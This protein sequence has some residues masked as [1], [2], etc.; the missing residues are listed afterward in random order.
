MRRLHK[1]GV[2]LLLS[3]ALV[4]VLGLRTELGRASPVA[5]ANPSIV[6]PPAV[7]VVAGSGFRSPTADST[8]ILTQA[9]FRDT[10][11]RQLGTGRVGIV[12]SGEQMQL[13]AGIGLKVF[14]DTGTLQVMITAQLSDQVPQRML[15]NEAGTQKQLSQFGLT[16]QTGQ[17][18]RQPDTKNIQYG[19]V[20]PTVSAPT[21]LTFQIGLTITPLFGIFVSPGEYSTELLRLLILPQPYTPEL[22]S[23]HVVLFDGRSTDVQVAG[24]LPEIA[25]D[26]SLSAGATLTAQ[27][28]G[29]AT[30]RLTGNGEVGSQTVAGTL[31]FPP[32]LLGGA[33]T[34]QVAPRTIYGVH[35][36]D[37]AGSHGGQVAFH[38]A[39]PSGLEATNVH[40]FWH[41]EEL[42][43]QHGETVTLRGL[44]LGD[45]GSEVYAIAD[46]QKGG[47]VLE[48]EVESNHAHLTVQPAGYTMAPRQ[49][50]LIGGPD[51]SAAQSQT[52][53]EFQ[54]A[55][56]GDLPKITWSV[57]GPGPASIDNEG[58]LTASKIP[59]ASGN[60]TVQA[61]VTVGDELITTLTQQVVVGRLTAAVT[62]AAGEDARFD[63][64]TSNGTAWRYTWQTKMPTD[65]NW[66]TLPDEKGA[67]LTLKNV[68]AVDAGR[69]VRV[70]I[71]VA[72]GFSGT[73]QVTSNVGVLYIEMPRTDYTLRTQS[74]FLFTA[75]DDEL[76]QPASTT[77]T[78][79]L[80]GVQE[81]QLGGLTWKA[82]APDA[83]S[84]S[85]AVVIT[86]S[87]TDSRQATVHTTGM[88][89]VAEI[90][91]RYRENGVLQ[92]SRVQLEVLSLADITVAAN[93]A[94]IF[95]VPTMTAPTS[96]VPTYDWVRMSG[97]QTVQVT[98][99]PTTAAVTQVASK[100]TSALN[101]THYQLTMQFDYQGQPVSLHS[102]VA[103]ISVT[104]PDGLAMQTLPSFAFAKYDSSRTNAQGT[105]YFAPTVAE[106][107]TGAFQ[108]KDPLP[109]TP[110]SDPTTADWLRDSNP[111][112]NTLLIS[113]TRGPES[114]E[115]QLG[116]KMTRFVSGFSGNSI[117]PQPETGALQLIFHTE[118]GTALTV[119]SVP[120]GSEDAT[121][122][123]K[124]SAL[125]AALQQAE[126]L[127][128]TVD[129]FL[130]LGPLP[131]TR[132][133]SYQ[134]ELTW[135]LALVPQP[136]D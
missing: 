21:W 42:P 9:N 88:P 40:W 41:G 26:F 33:A 95:Q 87:R 77:T 62:T 23:D 129:G 125:P 70:L 44:R 47:V 116:L 103:A 99:R 5:A 3:I 11:G 57:M 106:L 13:R 66:T 72:G 20:A 123:F 83:T 74:P 43:D 124:Q 15:G 2:L 85:G 84:S 10:A 31:Y 94:L 58:T 102:N 7:P 67:S 53:F 6:L 56:T 101:G 14:E 100:V 109:Q 76:G 1:K 78:V 110:G 107:I 32:L 134:A 30:L 113:D 50:L 120:I 25:P 133:N 34:I 51:T 105:S 93:N 97:G 29:S 27:A 127:T 126:V 130:K 82:I 111:T 91:A 79:T 117:A 65:A 108:G 135:E 136:E 48:R 16:Y 17:S 118:D 92:E 35:L 36:P 132:V 114:G 90:V 80:A 131:S 89:G 37:Q 39:L 69:Q 28:R 22:T 96:V 61:R 119:P 38:L 49:A 60:V 73:T 59:G 75:G 24:L 71:Q 104:P 81:D 128:F 112:D 4:I 18:G 68:Q 121:I 45:D 54:P 19:F 86:P 8:R 63:A 12:R 46:F 115:W 64:P 52:T 122:L 55:I 98:A